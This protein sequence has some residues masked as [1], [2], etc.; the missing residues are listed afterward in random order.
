MMCDLYD[1][2]WK[3]QKRTF[4]PIRWYVGTQKMIPIKYH[5]WISDIIY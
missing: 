5:E 4:R 1:R 3:R 2:N